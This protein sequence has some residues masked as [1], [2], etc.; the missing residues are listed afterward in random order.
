M[1]TT[2]VTTAATTYVSLFVEKSL[3]CYYKDGSYF[4]MQ[5]PNPMKI[6][7]VSSTLGTSAPEC[8]DNTRCCPSNNICTVEATSENLQKLMRTCDGKQICQVAVHRQK[9][10][11]GTTTYTDFESVTYTCDTAQGEVTT[12][13][14]LISLSL[15]FTAPAL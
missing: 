4:T 6:H 11:V 12:Q 9:C 13:I 5:C 7:I 1:E 2:A 10:P 8:V 14:H 3:G 15:V